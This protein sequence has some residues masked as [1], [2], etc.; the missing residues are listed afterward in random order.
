MEENAVEKPVEK[1]V[2]KAVEKPVVS[3]EEKVK[4]LP[5]EKLE[6][7]LL[8]AVDRIKVSQEKQMELN[9]QWEALRSKDA[10]EEER[11]RQLATEMEELTVKEEERRKALQ[12]MQQELAALKAGAAPV[13]TSTNGDFAQK[14][15]TAGCSIDVLQH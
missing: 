1:P 14:K 6:M 8:K 13:S 12:I 5:R 7:L 4:N 3:M 2:E 11:Q 15:G 10:E 9:E